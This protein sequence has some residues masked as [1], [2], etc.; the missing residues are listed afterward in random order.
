MCQPSTPLT[1]QQCLEPISNQIICAKDGQRTNT[2]DGSK[3]TAQCT[4]GDNGIE[5]FFHKYMLYIAIGGG[6][7]LLLIILI[8]VLSKK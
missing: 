7:F 4:G 6:A 2:W 8:V 3:C 1:Q 5:A